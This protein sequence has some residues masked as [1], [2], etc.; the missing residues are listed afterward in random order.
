MLDFDDVMIMMIMMI[1]MMM[2][3]MVVVV[4]PYPFSALGSH[5]LLGTGWRMTSQVIAWCPTFKFVVACS[6]RRVRR[7]FYSGFVL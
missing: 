4:P 3:T 2:M 7:T 6:D 1:M 5:C